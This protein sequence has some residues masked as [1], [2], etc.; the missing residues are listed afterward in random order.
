MRNP[1]TISPLLY[2]VALRLYPSHHRELFEDEML[3]VLAA[4]YMEVSSSPPLARLR[5]VLRECAGLISGAMMEHWRSLFLRGHVDR[6]ERNRFSKR[7]IY[8]MVLTCC[9]VLAAIV[10]FGFAALHAAHGNNPLLEQSLRPIFPGIVTIL[11][12]ANV[13]GSALSL[14][15]FAARRSSP[16]QPK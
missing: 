12:L 10:S 2:R 4:A 14:A 16:T 13:A 9:L 15:I 3:A 1:T 6:H 7:L 8:G 5:L 11:L